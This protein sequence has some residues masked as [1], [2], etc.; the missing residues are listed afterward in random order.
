MTR[1]ESESTG[2]GKKALVAHLLPTLTGRRRD[3]SLATIASELRMTVGAVKMAAS[4]LRNCYAE[5]LREE[6]TR[7]VADLA[8]VEPEIPDLFAALAH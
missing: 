6:I 7:T 3:V 2:A 8:D 5:I 1:L 4:R